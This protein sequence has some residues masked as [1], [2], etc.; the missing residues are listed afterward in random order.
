MSILIHGMKMP[1]V[2]YECYFC[3]YGFCAHLERYVTAIQ[4]RDADCPLVELPPHGRLIDADELA[5][6]LDFD[7]ENDLRALDSLDIV[8]KEREHIQ[9]DKDCKQNC[10]YYLSNCPTIVPAEEVPGHE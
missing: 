3:T 4:E 6:D 9:F 5:E 1:G 7:V 2:C 8:G 10:I